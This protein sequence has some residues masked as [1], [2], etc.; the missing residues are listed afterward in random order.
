MKVIG[1]SGS[2]ETMEIPDH[3][4]AKH[5]R[6]QSIC[7]FEED[8]GMTAA[9]TMKTEL[10]RLVALSEE[11][12]NSSQTSPEEH[13]RFAHEMGAFFRLFLRYLK[14]QSEGPLDWDKVLE[15]GSD[16]VIPYA[17]LESKG[18]PD[19]PS[20][21]LNRLAVVK[22]NGGLGTTMGCVGPKSAIEVRDGMSF[23]DLTVRQIECLNSDHNTAV[24]LLL[25]DSFNTETETAR[26]LRKYQ[27]RNVRISSFR[28]SRFP[29]IKKDSWLPVPQSPH[30]S[31]TGWYP[32]GHGD[33][34][35]ALNQSGLLDD[36]IARGI[37]Y[38]FISNIDNLG[39]TVNLPL[40]NHIIS[41]G[42]EFVMEVTDKTKA[43]IK[44]GT[45]VSY[46][47]QVRLLEIAQVPPEHKADFASIKK[48]RIFNTNNIWVSTRAIKRLLL[49]QDHP[50][51]LDLIVN[52]KIVEDTGVKVIQLETAVGAA[53]KHFSGAHGVN[54]PRS[55]FLP[56]KS[57]SDLF[58]VQSDLYTLQR[59]S[60]LLNPK[61]ST[62]GTAPLVKL[63]ENFK[64]VAQYLS[65]FASPPRILELD[66]LTVIGD[67]YFGKEVTLKGTVIIVANNGERI[68]IPS[69]SILEDKVV[70]GN[71]RIVDH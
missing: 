24:P 38:L 2:S 51:D 67:V 54:V 62:F 8:T 11:E 4:T 59:G 71:L 61:R 10:D 37:D 31:K 6:S 50:M 55:R 20:S 42:A 23:L 33:V 15:P 46:N 9:V 52:H 68:D 36:L 25:M 48:F 26:I 44:G 1:T 58:L 53:I 19:R 35:D 14:S 69:G 47:G 18:A 45:I 41:S 27:N 40:L 3:F 39:A 63:G 22:L 32:P 65:R 56:V 30:D 43:D 60:L 21:S 13:E 5:G 57:C 12:R 49:L 29:R 66:H 64:K 34:Y 7:Q 16:L 70:S 28:Q 17:T